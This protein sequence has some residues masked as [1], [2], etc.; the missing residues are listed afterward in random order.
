M[1]S[2]SEPMVSGGLV[3]VAGTGDCNDPRLTVAAVNAETERLAWQRSVA[4]QNPCGYRV[5]VHVAGGVV[6]AGGKLNG[7]AEPPG[8]L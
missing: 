4:A 5:P 1:A 7:A 2:V 3:V 8:P 6:V